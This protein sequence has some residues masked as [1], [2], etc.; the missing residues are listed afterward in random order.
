MTTELNSVTGEISHV[1]MYVTWHKYTGP[2]PR[3]QWMKFNSSS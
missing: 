2:V 1:I 3:L